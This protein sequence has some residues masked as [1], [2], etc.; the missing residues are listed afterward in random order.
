MALPGV[1]VRPIELRDIGS[2]AECTAAVIAERDYLA[3]QT[4][5]PLESTA[6]FVAANIRTGNPQYVADD[7]GRIVG[8]CDI[9]RSDIPVHRHC[10]ALGMGVLA[11]YR[12]QGLG[13]RL[14]DATLTAARGAGFERVDLVVYA[15]N[16]RA[17]ALYRSTGFVD[18]GRRTRG[19]KL[20]CD[21]D[22]ELLMGVVFDE[23]DT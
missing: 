11:Q 23:A 21:Y 16:S 14:I 13:R 18:I 10:G 20:G 2:F 6:Q 7:G 3:W 22:D 8:W 19:K 15:R 4:P 17:A 12:E 5:F 9:V 1:V